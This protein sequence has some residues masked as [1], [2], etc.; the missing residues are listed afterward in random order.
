MGAGHDGDRDAVARAVAVRRAE[1]RVQPDTGRHV[2]EPLAA[3]RVHGQPAHV[4]VPVAV[5]G[6]GPARGARHGRARGRGAGRRPGDG[7]GRPIRL[8]PRRLSE[9]H[10]EKGAHAPLSD[11]R[12]CCVAELR[13]LPD[14]ACDLRSSLR[15]N[16]MV[17]SGHTRCFCVMVGANVGFLGTRNL[18]DETRDPH[19][20]QDHDRSPTDQDPGP[21]QP[22]RQ[23]HVR[24]A[25]RPLRPRALPA[26]RPLDRP[27]L[28]DPSQPRAV[29]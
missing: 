15:T 23:L 12:T 8:R 2:G 18:G 6:E 10:A 21:L 22:L 7:R 9:S 4:G 5:R 29:A 11:A 13:P 16:P 19:R 25:A 14:N 27:R 1:V 26:L 24:P 28:T 20:D 17:R 3:A